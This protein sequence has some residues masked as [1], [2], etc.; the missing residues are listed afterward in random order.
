MKTRFLNNSGLVQCVWQYEKSK[1]I[2]GG[3]QNGV[4][5]FK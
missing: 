4:Q 2:T 5:G 1:E 3:I